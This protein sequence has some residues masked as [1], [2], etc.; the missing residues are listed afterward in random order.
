[1]CPSVPHSDAAR[2]R[3]RTSPGPHGGTSPSANSRAPGRAAV[4]RIAF[5]LDPGRW[6]VDPETARSG[7]RA[8]RGI[9][10]RGPRRWQPRE[11]Q[12]ARLAISETPGELESEA[13]TV[14]LDDVLDELGPPGVAVLLVEEV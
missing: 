1:M 14:L 9:I 6:E 7:D 3:T 2:T 13:P 5:M 12:W 8:G 4:L 11:F 10:A